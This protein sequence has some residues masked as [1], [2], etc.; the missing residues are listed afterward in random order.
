VKTGNQRQ[1]IALK[2][3]VV[4]GLLC[5]LQC[6]L[7]DMDPRL[8]KLPFTGSG[9]NFQSLTLVFPLALEMHARRR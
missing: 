2:C 4:D 7:Q 5:P 9:R 3:G 1:S 8:H 6:H